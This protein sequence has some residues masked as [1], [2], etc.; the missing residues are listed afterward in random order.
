MTRNKIEDYYFSETDAIPNNV[1]LPLLIYRKVISLE[2]DVAGRL[3]KTF[4]SHGWKPAWRYGIYDF[5]HYHSTAHEVIGVYRG[6]AN[7]VFGHDGGIQT[8]LNPGDVVVIPAGTGHQSIESTKDFHAVGAYPRGQEPDLI[9]AEP[10]AKS[11]AIQRIEKVNLP[12]EDPLY[13]EEGPLI[14]LW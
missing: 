3:E 10:S 1:L 11:D 2:G 13:G 7:V 8:W 5:A 6:R 4:Q 14:E 9:K 12:G